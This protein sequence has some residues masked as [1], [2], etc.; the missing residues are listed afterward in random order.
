MSFYIKSVKTGLFL[1]FPYLSSHSSEQNFNSWTSLQERAFKYPSP[2]LAF[3]FLNKCS[4]T[5]RAKV[6]YFDGENYYNVSREKS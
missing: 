5:S 1:Y 3:E 2:G 4:K 6:V